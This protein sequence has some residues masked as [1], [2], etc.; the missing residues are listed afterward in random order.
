MDR[1][2]GT[3]DDPA[4]SAKHIRHEMSIP[5]ALKEKVVTC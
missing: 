4:M 2:G 5:V 3:N 1:V